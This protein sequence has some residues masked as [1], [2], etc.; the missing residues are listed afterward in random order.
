MG[1]VV[2]FY[3]DDRKRVRP[4]ISEKTNYKLAV[5][6]I[7]KPPPMKKMMIKDFPVY[8]HPSVPQIVANWTKD[9][10]ELIPKKYIDVGDRRFGVRKIVIIPRPP[11]RKN[12]LAY[13]AKVQAQAERDLSRVGIRPSGKTLVIYDSPGVS[14]ELFINA[15]THEY[16]HHVWETKLSPAQIRD[17]RKI[18][19]SV[20]YNLDEEDFAEAFSRHVMRKHNPEVYEKFFSERLKI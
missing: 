19:R 15:V 5:P 9:A 4:I 7:Q 14:K 8:V 1:R 13:Y 18:Y 11:D 6:Q 12:V 2:G 3:T 16:G 20:Y 10:L 17:W